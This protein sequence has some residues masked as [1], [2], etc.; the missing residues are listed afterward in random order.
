MNGERLLEQEILAS[1]ARGEWKP[2]RN[3]KGKIAR[4]RA[5]GN[6]DFLDLVNLFVV[7]SANRKYRIKNAQEN[8][9]LLRSSKLPLGVR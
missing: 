2:I 7:D 5:Q 8:V 3:Q 4:L 9:H 6:G 1:F